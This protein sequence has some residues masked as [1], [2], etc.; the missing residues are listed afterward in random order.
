M[1]SVRYYNI[2]FDNNPNQLVPGQCTVQMLQTP[3]PS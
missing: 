3:I 2:S 1:K